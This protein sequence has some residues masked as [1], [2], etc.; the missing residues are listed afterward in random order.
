MF[1]AGIVVRQIRYLRYPQKNNVAD[2]TVFR[3]AISRVALN[4]LKVNDVLEGFFAGRFVVQSVQ[5][6]QLL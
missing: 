4:E 5:S 6:L 1:D 3:K 2:S